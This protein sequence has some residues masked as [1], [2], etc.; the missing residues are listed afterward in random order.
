[1]FPRS[2]RLLGKKLILVLSNLFERIF[3]YKYCTNILYSNCMY[4]YCKYNY[5]SKVDCAIVLV[6]AVVAIS[7]YARDYWNEFTNKMFLRLYCDGGKLLLLRWKADRY[8]LLPAILLY[9]I[10]ILS[11]FYLLPAVISGIVFILL[12]VWIVF[13]PLKRA[14]DGSFS[15]L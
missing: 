8:L 14:I 4:Q 1:M 5:D 9:G 13:L 3:P 7:R 10:V 2:K 6:F 11:Q 12:I 15:S